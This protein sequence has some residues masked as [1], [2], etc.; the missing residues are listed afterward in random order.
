[1]P[2]AS[3]R[4]AA[5]RSGKVDWIEDPAPDAVPSL[6][7]AGFK[8]VTNVY[9]HNW[10]WHLSRL[11]GSCW[12]DIRVREAANLAIDRAGMVRLLNGLMVR[13]RGFVPPSSPW[14]G[15]P[16]FLVHYDM[17]AAK[18]LLA[19]AGYGPKH[20]IDCGKVL[21]SS[22]GSGQMQPI[23][24]NEYIQQKL[25][26][27]GI[28]VTLKVMDWN[29]LLNA[30][31]AGA[32]SPLSLGAE[33]INVSYFIQDPFTALVRFAKSSLVP[34]KGNNWGYYHSA[35]MDH[36]IDEVQTT[37]DPAKQT[38]LLQKI[39]EIYVNHAL[40]LMVGH[41]VNPRAMSPRVHGF[42]QPQNW[43]QNFS[44]IWMSH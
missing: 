44:S 12:N 27:V 30:W 10:T 34:P 29:A 16:T 15:H 8:I 21:I 17:A 41:D 22:S 11:P 13:A 9:P 5:L 19:E 26:D 37:F 7:A 24:M 39:H 31:R 28:K 18:K 4:T 36:L 2:D 23:P 40:F 32:K 43:F 33:A 6:R 20:P 1:M 25:A 3:A 14:F 42:V 38:A 35:E